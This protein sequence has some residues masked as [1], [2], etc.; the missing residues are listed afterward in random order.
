M[1]VQQWSVFTENG[2]VGGSANPAVTNF[3]IDTAAGTDAFVAANLIA[4]FSYTSMAI[5]STVAGIEVGVSVFTPP[6]GQLPVIF[7]AVEY[8]ALVAADVNLYPITAYGGNVGAGFLAALGSGAVLR[9][10]TATAGRSGRGRLTTPWLSQDAVD[11]FGRLSS[12]AQLKLDSGAFDYLETPF[13]ANH[14][15]KNATTHLP[16][17]SMSVTQQLGRVRSRRN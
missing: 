6:S 14:K 15:L 13:G 2:D 10:Q 12:A 11:G 1:T 4:F 17:T 3:F 16:I 5:D 8:A 9:K 7:P